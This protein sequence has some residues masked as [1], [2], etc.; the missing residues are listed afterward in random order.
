MED[1]LPRFEPFSP[2][3]FEEAFEDRREPP[4]IEVLEELAQ[5]RPGNHRVACRASGRIQGERGECPGHRNRGDGRTTDAPRLDN[6]SEDI[7]RRVAPIHVRVAFRSLD[8]QPTFS[9]DHFPQHCEVGLE[10]AAAECLLRIAQRHFQDLLATQR[11]PVVGLQAGL[12]S[13]SQQIGPERESPHFVAPSNRRRVDLDL[14]DRSFRQ[15]PP[16]DAVGQVRDRPGRHDGRGPQNVTAGEVSAEFEPARTRPGHD[17]VG[18]WP[19][20]HEHP[21]GGVDL[22]P[23]AR[24]LQADLVRHRDADVS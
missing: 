12:P 13:V 8:S 22:R 4:G 18:R 3:L 23:A 5:V 10:S 24:D 21:G 11:T 17:A 7:P 15:R 6:L 16:L 14:Q 9:R 2:A 1:L 20:D 19:L